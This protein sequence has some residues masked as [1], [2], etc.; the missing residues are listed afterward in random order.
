MAKATKKSAKKVNKLFT[1]GYEQTPSKAVLDEL[2][3]AGV[4]LLVDVRAVA[5]SRRPGFSKN[6]LAAGLDERGIAYLHLRGLGTPKE[7]REAA[8][9]GAIR[10]AAQDLLETSEDAAGQGRTRRA[11]GAGEE[12]RPGLHPLLRARPHTLSPAMDRGDHRGARPGEGGES[13]R[14]AGMTVIPGRAKREPGMTRETT[15]P[16]PSSRNVPSIICTQPPPTWAETTAPSCLRTRVSKQARPPHVD[17]LADPQFQFAVARRVEI[18]EQRRGRDGRAAGGGIFGQARW[19][20]DETSAPAD[21]SGCSLRRHIARVEIDG[22]TA[23][24]RK[25][26][27]ECRGIG[28]RPPQRLARGKLHHQKRQSDRDDVR[29]MAIGLHVSR[30]QRE[31]GRRLLRA[32]T[33]SSASAVAAPSVRHRRPR[34][35]R[36]GFRPAPDPPVP[37]T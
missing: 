5:S 23:V 36:S 19:S 11:I 26:L 20:P 9:S 14:A 4:K 35:V 33:A 13:G 18:G 22:V 2:E 27:A 7:G 6:Q 15:H 21:R 1:I 29:R 28:L 24:A 30:R 10:R 25:S 17:A 37:R 16:S 8:R 31:T 3:H 34:F 32:A 12:I